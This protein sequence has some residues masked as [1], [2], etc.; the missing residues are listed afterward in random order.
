MEGQV[1][2][3]CGCTDDTP[4]ITENGPCAWLLDDLCDACVVAVGN[5]AYPK[6]CQ[7]CGKIEEE[8]IKDKDWYTCGEGRFDKDGYH[9]H[10]WFAWRGI[11]RPNKTVAAAQFKCPL[12]ALHPRHLRGDV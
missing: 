7:H 12:F 8:K 1:C 9:G 10:V 6:E 3:L 5:I 4:C 11:S 2:R